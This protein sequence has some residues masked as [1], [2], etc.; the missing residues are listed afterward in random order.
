MFQFK[1]EQLASIRRKQLGDALI[2]SFAG[3]PIRAQWNPGEDCV[4]ATDPLEHSTSFEF[5]AQGFIGIVTSPT[6]RQWQIVNRADGNPSTLRNPAGHSFG[7][8]YSSA[9]QLDTISS[10]GRARLRMLYNERLIQ[11]G[12]SFPDGTHSAI[13]LTSWNA[14]ALTTD[15]LG[16]RELFEYDD[17]RRLIAFTDG[18]GARTQ[19]CYGR[20]NRPDVAVDPNGTVESYAYN[21]KGS[22]RQ[23]ATDTSCIDLDCNDKGRPVRIKFSDGTAA[24]YQY[25]SSGRATEAAIGDHL[26][27]A[28]WNDEGGLV[29]E[30]NG[31]AVLLY[32]YDKA[33]RLTGMTYP[34]G[35]KIEYQWDADS[36]LVEVLDWN[37]GKHAVHYAE[38]DRGFS[39]RGPNGVDTHT[40]LTDLGS[41]ENIVV[42]R[43]SKAILSLG[44]AYDDENRVSSLRD[45]AVGD[46]SF[47][48]DAEGQ[49]LSARSQNDAL[50]ESFQYDAAGNPV[51]LSGKPARF[52]AANQMLSHGHSRF[53]YDGRGNLVAMD[54][55]EGIWRFAYN[56]RNYIVRAESPSG[57]VTTYVYDAYGRRIRKIRPDSVVEFTWAGEQLIGEVIKMGDSVVRRDYLYFPGTF[58]P[59]AMR[60]AGKVYSYHTDHLGTP[61]MLTAPDGSIAWAASYSCFGEARIS[62][63]TVDNPLRAPGQYFD[64]ETGFYYNRFRYY[65]PVMGRYLSRDPLGLLADS[66]FYRYVGNNPINQADPL[67]LV[68]WLKVAAITCAI[69]AV[70]AVA[71]VTVAVVG[72][73][74]VAAAPAALAAVGLSASTA[75]IAGS[76][77]AAAT[78]IAGAAAGALSEGLNENIEG[79]K[80]CW[81]CILKAAGVGALGALPIAA[82]AFVYPPAGLLGPASIAISAPYGLT[83]A[84]GAGE[85]AISYLGNCIDGANPS[86]NMKGFVSTVA[87]HAALP[88]VGKYVSEDAE[89]DLPGPAIDFS[90]GA[91]TG[92]ADKGIDEATKEE[93]D[94]PGTPKESSN[95]PT[96]AASKNPSKVKKGGFIGDDIGGNYA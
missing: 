17:H 49:L 4:V 3:A 96:D 8:T 58:A 63:A 10:N 1:Q 79:K 61:R 52:D 38:H 60:V 14:P 91:A 57:E 16:V 15:R 25:D 76:A 39:L 62:R 2:K 55:A 7:M 72:P 23:I 82:L 93:P 68:Q 48:Y 78:L 71:V 35:E 84:A 59:L 73:V 30:H 80:I 51:L 54:S 5:D 32:E 33:G 92:A 90:S 29:E 86:C 56:D 6:G 13:D 66:N 46:R 28:V 9:G 44:Y 95:A 42:A 87:V 27:K 74:L 45:S 65:S 26:C 36:R 70:A 40:Q 12:A 94:V 41:A 64:A 20:W 24:Y 83:A 31:D 89:V 85:G 88:L 47:C 67:G 19:F 21:D 69:V 18:K 81:P 34:S 37:G 77:A 11:T 22:V 50:N 75:V 43:E 53:A